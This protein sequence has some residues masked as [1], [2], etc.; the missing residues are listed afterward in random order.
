[1]SSFNFRDC[2]GV[3]V[4]VTVEMEEVVDIMVLVVLAEICRPSNYKANLLV[5]VVV[6]VVVFTLRAEKENFISKS[7][8]KQIVTTKNMKQ[9]IPFS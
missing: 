2:F 7:F 3:M 9:V 1:M 6:V 5:V 4:T 8:L